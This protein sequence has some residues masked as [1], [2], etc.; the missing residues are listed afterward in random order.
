MI[1][2]ILVCKTYI[3]KFV[4]TLLHTLTP[5]QFEKK[6]NINISKFGGASSMYIH[7]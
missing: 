4:L 7:E 2:D 3:L 6:R 5:I 1:K